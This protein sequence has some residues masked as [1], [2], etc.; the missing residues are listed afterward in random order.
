MKTNGYERKARRG[1]N[2]KEG[3]R[4]DEE[5][6]KEDKGQSRDIKDKSTERTR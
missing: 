1:Q 6:Q 4:K 2:R 5:R 3:Q